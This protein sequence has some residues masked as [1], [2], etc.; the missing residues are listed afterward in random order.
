M[1]EVVEQLSEQGAEVIDI[2]I[3]ELEES[4]V[5]LGL[6][7]HSF[8]C[9]FVQEARVAHLVT[10]LSEMASFLSSERE[11]NGGLMVRK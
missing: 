3:A 9:L 6:K 8:T 7:L 1:C 5:K 10:I 2:E 4:S 11:E